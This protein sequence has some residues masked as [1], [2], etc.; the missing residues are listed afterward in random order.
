MALKVEMQ[1]V[2][3]LQASSGSQ[4]RIYR[5]DDFGQGPDHLTLFPYLYHVRNSIFLPCSC[6]V[7]HSLGAFRSTL[8]LSPL[9]YQIHN[10]LGTNVCNHYGR[11]PRGIADHEKT[12]GKWFSCIFMP[13][14]IITINIHVNNNKYN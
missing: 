9:F 7:Y 1:R 11:I 14:T 8:A 12:S 6:E 2:W 5:L 4:L 3:Y 10:N 13:F